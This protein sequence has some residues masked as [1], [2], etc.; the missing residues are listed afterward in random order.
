MT[1]MSQSASD[2]EA[3]YIHLIS[4]LRDLARNM[5]IDIAHHLHQYL[6]ELDKVEITFDGG[7]SSL[8]FAGAAMLIQNSTWV[9]SKKVDFLYALFQQLLDAMHSK[10]KLQQAR[11]NQDNIMES[12]NRGDESEEFLLLDDV[13]SQGSQNLFVQEEARGGS[14]SLL[15]HSTPTALIPLDSDERGSTQLH[16]LKGEPIGNKN[17]FSMNSYTASSVGV[18]LYDKSMP[19]NPPPEHLRNVNTSQPHQSSFDMT[20][21]HMPDD[22]GGGGGDCGGGCL[23]DL[24][25]DLDRVSQCMPNEPNYQPP[26]KNKM[27][28]SES[29]KT[30]K[31][32]EPLNPHQAMKRLEKLPRRGK[33]YH[34]LK[35]EMLSGTEKLLPIN[36]YCNKEIFAHVSKFPRNYPKYILRPC[37]E[38]LYYKECK[39]R[40]AVKKELSLSKVK[41][42][43]RDAVKDD[44]DNESHCSD[45]VPGDDIF[46]DDDD[47][48]NGGGRIDEAEMLPMQPNR[49]NVDL[50]SQFE[51]TSR[52]DTSSSKD[53][54]YEDL[55]RKYTEEVFMKVKQATHLTKT[56]QIVTRWEEKLS[57]VLEEEDSHRPYD[58]RA[59]CSKVLD[60]FGPM[61]SKQTI[62]FSQVVR[63]ATKIDAARHF[64]ATLQLVNNYNVELTSP[65]TDN[66]S[67]TND[68]EIT[69]LSR[70]QHFEDLD[71]FQT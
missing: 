32:L 5:G 49:L 55:V 15:L 24:D 48:D 39:R 65:E 27:I 70:R 67:V 71:E 56:A 9:Y 62:K 41:S 37:F 3:R 17:D 4:P 51:R 31:V 1:D 44:S 63:G 50:D 66:K 69:L 30:R 64:L 38:T 34:L 36:E 59:Y 53:V 40:K 60:K 23:S 57:T 26:L 19:L 58:I 10:T 43:I 45:N 13:N 42:K 25:N 6:E 21:G 18:L 29:E 14:K 52:F 20:N 28:L 8:N 33:T 7:Q 47:D 68:F 54:A 12:N 46:D 35:E 16:D 11:Q 22:G 61:P 2:R